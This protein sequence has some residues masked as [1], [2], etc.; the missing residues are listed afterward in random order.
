MLKLLSKLQIL[1]LVFVAAIVLSTSPTVAT[2]YGCGEYGEGD[3]NEDP[4]CIEGTDGTGGTGGTG[5]GEGDPDGP[6][7]NDPDDDRDPDTEPGDDDEEEPDPL[8]PEESGSDDD[9]QSESEAGALESFLKD[10][11]VKALFGIIFL[12]G[13]WFFIILLRRRRDEPEDEPPT[14]FP[15]G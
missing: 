12:A 6:V 11:G 13:L 9:D 4:A 5:G 1:L 2:P 15:Q 10:W 14:Y 7:D 3:F 8:L